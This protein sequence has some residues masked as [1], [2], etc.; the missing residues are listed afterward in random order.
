MNIRAVKAGLRVSEVP[1]FERL[2]MHGLS[3]LNAASDGMRVLKT[4]LR[5]RRS[6]RR[7]PAERARV[8]RAEN[9]VER[10][11]LVESLERTSA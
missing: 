6:G 11:R 2:R 4:I 10:G 9:M 1:S 7:A 3:N 8:A 5:E